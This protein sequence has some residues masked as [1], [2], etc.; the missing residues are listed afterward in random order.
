MSAILDKARRALANNDLP[1]VLAHVTDMFGGLQGLRELPPFPG[2]VLEAD[3]L[4]EKVGHLLWQRHASG[5][6]PS[7]LS[8]GALV[9]ATMLFPIGGHT[10]VIRDLANALPGPSP[11]LWLTMAHPSAAKGLKLEALERTGLSEKTRVFPSDQPWERTEQIVQALV[12]LRPDPL[13]LLHHPTD[14]VAVIAAAAAAAMG[15]TV[16]LLHHADSL[17]SAGLYLSGLLIIDFTPRACGFTRSMLGLRSA[18]VPLTCPDPGPRMGAFMSSGAIRTALG[19][20]RDKVNRMNSPDYPEL[21]ATL[22]ET[23]GGEHV[24]IGTLDKTTIRNVLSSL[25]RRGISRE[26][27][28]WVPQAPT[29]VQALREYQVDLFV[30]TYPY[31]GAR[32]AVE[33]MAAGVPMLWRSPTPD[34]DDFLTQMKYPGAP[35]W[36]GIEELQAILN[37]ADRDWLSRQGGAARLW[38]EQMHHPRLWKESFTNLGP[39]FDRPLPAGFDASQVMRTILEHSLQKQKAP[40]RSL[41]TSLR[42]FFRLK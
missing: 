8:G 39:A 33:V 29:L 15:S 19:G 12:D 11:S 28:I 23:T 22:L 40:K 10:P 6:I 35:V 2:G 31:G 27:V 14:C 25:R 32:T 26:R 42:R 41:K 24:H 34:Q 18:W 7:S 17:P 38:Y 36:R 13:F 16:F 37:Q 5:K 1:D 9:L 20:G 3:R 4:L 21:V 30:N